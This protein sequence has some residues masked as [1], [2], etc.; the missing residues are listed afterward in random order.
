MP[1]N[2][3]QVTL[4]DPR[5]NAEGELCHGY[6]ELRYL[7][8]Q[9]LENARDTIV[10]A[11]DA[12]GA[13]FGRRWGGMV[14]TYRSENAEVLLVAAGSLASEATVAV[15]Q[16]REDGCKAGVLGI[17]VYRPFPKA[18]AI[19]E[20]RGA[21]LV[22]VFDKSLSYGNEGPICGDLKAALYGS[23]STPAVHGYIGGL[24]GRD[25]KAH[26]LA[27]ATKQSLLHLAAGN[28][29]KETGWI[30]CQI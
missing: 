28:R 17:R 2:L 10:S 15:D 25:V 11:D 16:L 29:T 20:T 5:L 22:I 24:G 19:R 21:K 4:A 7:L 12:F 30:N 13:S 27:D 6:L 23:E 14:W 18:E 8:E 26:E 1:W 9:S 3:N